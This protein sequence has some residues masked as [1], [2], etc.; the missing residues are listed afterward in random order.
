MFVFYYHSLSPV[1]SED[2]VA[3]Q[4]YCPVMCYSGCLDW[5][6]AVKG[7]RLAAQRQ[8]ANDIP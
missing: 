1:N 7:L 5:P 4:V 8:P 3:A 2:A 6:A